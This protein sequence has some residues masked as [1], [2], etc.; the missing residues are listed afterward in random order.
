MFF[1]VYFCT[2]PSQQHLL[3]GFRKEHGHG[4]RLTVLIVAL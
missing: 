4:G 1:F 3:E 2:L